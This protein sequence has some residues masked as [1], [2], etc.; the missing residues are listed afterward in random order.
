M[1]RSMSV[2][3][4]EKSKAWWMQKTMDKCMSVIGNLITGQH[5]SR[6]ADVRSHQI[7]RVG[8]NIYI[9]SCRPTRLQKAIMV[10]AKVMKSPHVSRA[11]FGVF[12]HLLKYDV[13]SFPI[14]TLTVYFQ[15]R[16]QSK[17]RGFFHSHPVY[18]TTQCLSKIQYQQW[19]TSRHD[20][21]PW[22]R[23]LVQAVT[24]Q[25]LLCKSG[26]HS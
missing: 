8:Q 19:E 26:R 6:M 15:H 17:V 23:Q 14:W 9:K 25:F 12:F 22:R 20:T 3:R 16:C 13:I 4:I 10:I 1:G 5:I 11:G 18:N 2:Q 7:R 21:K 24:V